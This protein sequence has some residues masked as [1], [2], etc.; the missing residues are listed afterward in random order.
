MLPTWFQP[1]TN[2]SPLTYFA[3]GARKATY[4]AKPAGTKLLIL[5]ALAVFFL[6]L[7][8]VAFPQLD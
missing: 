3:R 8:A 1:F 2:L 7:G 4:L 6:A 5:A